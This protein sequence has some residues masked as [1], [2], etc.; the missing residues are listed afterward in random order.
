[1]FGV[2]VLST[3]MSW[4]P[5]FALG[6]CGPNRH[7]NAVGQCV[8]G[9]QNQDYCLKRTGHKATRMPDGTMRCF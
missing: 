1:M 8:Y 9:G 2:V 5:A 4:T 6:D 3:A 7:R